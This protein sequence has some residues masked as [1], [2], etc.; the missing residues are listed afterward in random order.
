MGWAREQ[1]ESAVEGLVE[2]RRQGGAMTNDEVFA[3]FVRAL[4][5]IE[6]R[7]AANPGA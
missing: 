4:E 7:P 1:L 3:L 2:E 6:S 5:T